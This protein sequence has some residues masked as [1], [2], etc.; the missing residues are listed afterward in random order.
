MKSIVIVG[1]F[2]IVTNCLFSDD[3]VKK[4]NIEV[5]EQGD[6]PEAKKG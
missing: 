6:G 1:L 2:L 5:L 3:L 4:Y